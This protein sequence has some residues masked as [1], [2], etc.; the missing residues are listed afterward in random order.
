MWML[1]GV[2]R[3]VLNSV[4]MF[5]AECHACEMWHLLSR[6]HVQAAVIIECVCGT[7]LGGKLSDRRVNN[8]ME[9]SG[10][11]VDDTAHSSF[12]CHIHLHQSAFSFLGAYDLQG[13]AG[14][15]CI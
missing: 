12:S 5:T 3:G 6:G 8:T 15:G 11:A 14:R 1:L 13:G 10:L 7:G 9:H 2:L 4:S